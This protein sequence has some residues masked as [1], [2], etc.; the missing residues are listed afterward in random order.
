MQTYKQLDPTEALKNSIPAMQESLNSVASNFSGT[1]FPTE[2][3][4]VGMKC[5]RTD[6]GAKGTEYVCVGIQEDGTGEWQDVNNF[7]LHA[8]QAETDGEGNRINTIYLK[9]TDAES[10]YLKKSE[11]SG[12][13]LSKDDAAITY[14][15][16]TTGESLSR[17]VQS[18]VQAVKTLQSTVSGHTTSIGSINTQIKNLQTSVGSIDVSGQKFTV[19]AS[20]QAARNAY[21][22]G[23]IGTNDGTTS[24]GSGNITSY[25]GQLKTNAGVAA[26]TYTLKDIL[27]KLIN[28]SHNHSYIYETY[29]Y[30]CNCDCRCDCSD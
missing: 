26:G 30:N 22:T 8:G 21:V 16:K 2:N 28:L 1:A 29:K 18:N 17:D 6:I 12:A 11:A 3:L 20:T 9:K 19:T 5:V 4:F 13:Y 15:P 7:A 25:R 14:F 24:S 10:I 27:Q 23:I